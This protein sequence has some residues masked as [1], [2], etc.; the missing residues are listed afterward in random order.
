VF[1]EPPS[2]DTGG[3]GGASDAADERMGCGLG[4]RGEGGGDWGGGNVDPP[5]TSGVEVVGQAVVGPYQVEI[6]AAEQGDNLSNWL[7]LNGYAIPPGADDAMQHYIEGGA[8]FLGIKLAPDLPS[9]PIDALTFRYEADVPMIP[10]RLTAIATAPSME[11][12]AYIM[13]EQRWRP[14][15]W[16][17]VEFDYDTVSWTGVDTTDYPEI[18]SIPL[19]DV[20]GRGWITEFAQPVEGIAGGAQD[21][22]MRAL[23]T[24]A[25]F[26]TR[27]HS[28]LTGPQMT[29]D[30]LW[31]PD[32]DGPIVG[33]HH[34]L[35]GTAP[36]MPG[37]GKRPMGAGL[38]FGPLLLAGLR[39]RR[40]RRG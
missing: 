14:L 4:G 9:G 29:Q 24:G 21:E 30:P 16:E 1:E 11:I 19:Q 40:P 31:V 13:G 7:L 33:N 2:G 3:S 32:P 37:P 25:A 23:F 8:S 15:N 17:D 38:V 5:D 20:D 39:R 26:L 6:I 36:S 28:A 12:V 35:W 10:L 34:T 22:T 18:Y 27:Y